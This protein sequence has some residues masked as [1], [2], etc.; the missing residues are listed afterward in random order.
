LFSAVPEYLEVVERFVY[1][2]QYLVSPKEL[3]DYFRSGRIRKAWNR[4]A[5]VE[6]AQVE[7]RAE[8]ARLRVQP[9]YSMAVACGPQSILLLPLVAR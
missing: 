6:T 8:V 2:P 9:P 1:G 3:T 7:Q 4:H 5:E